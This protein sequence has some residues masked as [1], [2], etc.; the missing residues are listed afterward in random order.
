MKKVCLCL[1]SALL[2]SICLTAQTLGTAPNGVFT[3]ADIEYW[4]GTGSNEA[5]LVLV[6]NDGK[7]PQALVW[8]YRYDGSK[9]MKQM[10]EDI[11]A[12]D[13]RFYFQ[14]GSGGF[15]TGFGIDMNGNGVFTLQNPDNPSQ[16][17]N[18]TTNSISS[19]IDLEGFTPVEP[20]DR[21]Q[22]GWGSVGFWYLTNNGFN[23]SAAGWTCASFTSYGGGGGVNQTNATYASVPDPNS[24][25]PSLKG[26]GT[27]TVSQNVA[28]VIWNAS[29]AA[30]DYRIELKPASQADWTGAES[31]NVSDTFYTFTGLTS[32]TLYN[33][34]VKAICGSDDESAWSS[35]SFRTPCDAVTEL[36]YTDNFDSYGTGTSIF[37]PCWTKILNN[38]TASNALYVASTQHLSGTAALVFQAPNATAEV[39]AV[40]PQLDESINLRDLNVVF[41]LKYPQLDN[42]MIVGVVENDGT[43]VGIDTV[44][45]TISNTWQRREVSLASY[46][47][48]GGR[49]ALKEHFVRAS[50]NMWV[51]DLSIDYIP[52][53]QTL[54]NQHLTEILHNEA[55][56][57]WNDPNDA[58]DYLLEVSTSAS[59][60]SGALTF[61]STTTNCTATGLTPNTW[62]TYRVKAICGSSDESAWA[63]GRFKTACGAIDELPYAENFD[64]Y[65]YGDDEYVECWTKYGIGTSDKI[66]ISNSSSAS[67]NRCLY[68]YSNR[69]NGY[70]AT[71]VLPSFEESLDLLSVQF[72]LK[73][74]ALPNGIMVGVLEGDNFVAIDTVLSNASDVWEQKEVSLASYGGEGGK[75]AFRVYSNTTHLNSFALYLDDVKVDYAPACPRPQNLVVTE[76]TVATTVDLTWTDEDNSR[77]VVYY[78]AADEEEYTMEA[79]SANTISISN[80]S[81][82]TSYTFQV[83]SICSNGDTVKAIAAVN[84]ST[85]CYESAIGEFPFIESF[86][87]G[88]DCWTSISSTTEANNKWQ[89]VTSGSN[90]SCSPHDGSKMLFFNSYNV[91]NNKW[92][93]I[94]S[95]AMNFP[96][97]MDV[98][99]DMFHNSSNNSYQDRVLLYVNDQPTLENATLIDSVLRYRSSNGW[100]EHSFS[101]PAST[102]GTQYIIIKAV[103]AYGSNIFLD[104]LK[105]KLGPTCIAVEDL[106]AIAT[107]ENATVAWV[108]PRNVGNYAIELSTTA[109]DWSEATSHTS[110]DT[111]YTFTNLTPNTTYHYRVKAVCSSTDESAWAEGSFKTACV[112]VAELPYTENF[113]SYSYG[114]DVYADCWDKSGMG[115]DDKINVSS[116][117]PASGSRCL[118]FKSQRANACSATAL[119]PSFEEDLTLLSLQ[120]KFKNPNSYNGII[121]GVSEAD[122]LISIDTVYATRQGIWEQKEV[123]FA[124][125]EGEGG[126]I[127]LKPYSTSS[128]SSSC[129]L[130]V[131]DIEVNYSPACSRPEG[132]AIARGTEA[133]SVDLSWT[134]EDNSRWVVYYKASEE[135]EYTM[136]DFTDNSGSIS[137]LEY[138]TSYTFGVASICSNG[139]TVRA[140]ST[141]EYVTPMMAENVPYTCSFDSADA[142]AWLLK[143]STNTNKWH[144]GTPNG[145]T[146]GAL[147]I[148]KD[149]GDTAGYKDNSASIVIAEKLF[150]TGTGDS[151][152]I[153]F[154]LTVGG[155][156]SYDYLKVYWVPV[157]TVYNAVNTS[158]VPYYAATN[159]GNVL[160]KNNSNNYINLLTGTQTKSVTIANEPNTL[161]KLVFVWRNDGSSG[162]QPGAIIANLSIQPTG[163]TPE[164]APCDA[165]TALAVS[166]ITETSAEVSWT[167]TATSYEVRLNGEEAETVSTTS[168]T[169]TDLTTGTAYTVDV[170]A[171]CEDNQSA[172]VRISFTT[173]NEQ[174]ITAPTVTTLAATNIT[175][176]AATLNGTITAGSEEIT[177]Q[178]FKYK[179]ATA[180][181]WTTVSATGENI[182]ATVNNLTAETAYEYK[183]F[184]TTAS[185]TVEGTVMNFTTA[186]V[187]VIAPTVTTLAATDV[188]YEAATLNGT[189]TA[190]S[191]EITT[192]GFMYK[193][194]AATDWTTVSATGTTL[195]ATIDNLTAETAY[196][197]KAFAT[198]A[199]G[200]VEG[201]VMNFTTAAVPVVA[202]TVTTLAATDVTYEAATLNGTIT[203]G[204]EEITAQGFKYKASTATEWTTVSATGENIAATVNNLTAE[205]AYEYKAFATTASGT[206]EGEVMNFTTVAA[207]VVAPT[208]TTLAATGITHETATLNGTIS[209]GSETITAQGFE[210]KAEGVEN[211]SSVEANG[212]NM[213]ATLS[214]LEASTTYEF[215][216]FATTESGNTYGETM[217]FTTLSASGLEQIESGLSAIVY[218]NP[219]KDKATLSL[220]GLKANATITISDLQGRIIL[221]DKLQAGVESHEIDTSGFESGVYY[222]RVI[223]GNNV[224][225]QK[226]IVE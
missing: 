218:P 66:S 128:Q 41:Q 19:S 17:V 158:T 135:E 71:V 47:G 56:I 154:D 85:P 188:T 144:I 162:R 70:T 153:S 185:G 217:T 172:W 212:E 92:T 102:T 31:D 80:L 63:E 20:E 140:F 22:C 39:I 86:E 225:T 28:S 60:W 5:A 54:S 109:S 119:L 165:P 26:F 155:E 29:T 151:L 35:L 94:I 148:S 117:S 202:P 104:N 73:N 200:T 126:R 83:A 147:Y 198:T 59:D 69:A 157:D 127:T 220:K 211:W 170:R 201:T 131:D 190:G 98:S 125:Y 57:E 52:A 88:I 205:T 45:N 90:P 141:V 221:S 10:C 134:D 175:H 4:V 174:G 150:N 183:A 36:P 114:D 34:R 67:G 87:N 79:S 82:Q 161:R 18:P 195:T 146:T 25:C 121:V 223:S 21:W 103:S 33:C 208:V 65:Y 72:K 15:V 167:G 55:T 97:N 192:Q 48:Q 122:T 207:P 184:A 8:G 93:A 204:S 214:D 108:D 105:V 95:P 62:Y 219:A 193:A 196:E 76:G 50:G 133:T 156:G 68:L 142:T 32:N 113:D 9:S 100:Q 176:E 216:A 110:A 99:F 124:S 44:Y 37:P 145:E 169:F 23:N 206:V 106:S 152:T 129:I 7:T 163:E 49:I 84:Y 111:T 2:T 191:E 1:L 89:V 159:Y 182:A 194:A 164:P 224:N 226:L 137:G 118:Y 138:A 178:G 27:T 91:Q 136:A 78:K 64:S 199:S 130:Y 173:Q 112:P 43:F 75:I 210:Y 96:R 197:Y 53:C 209:A 160:M 101:L 180:T 40:A 13:P 116:S 51:D 16:V 139:D 189:I 143:N 203:A 132:L 46:T 14:E 187:P 171:V 120:F 215:R 186:A 179:A 81:L 213:S 181:D 168:K 123:S 38:T 74:P 177:A 24:S 149:G 11:A 12:A 77:W 30:L 222:I 115:T 58:G 6:F 166:N 107:A 3:A 42:G 61:T